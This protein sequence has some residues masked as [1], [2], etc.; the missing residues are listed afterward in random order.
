MYFVIYTFLRSMHALELTS[1]NTLCNEDI[2][3]YTAT[4]NDATPCGSA[5]NVWC[6]FSETPTVTLRFK[7][8]Q[9]VRQVEFVGNMK[10]RISENSEWYTALNDF[11][12][13]WSL[14]NAS[15]E[16]MLDRDLA[17]SELQFFAIK[18]ENGNA[19]LNVFGCP[20]RY[21]AETSF[22]FNSTSR[23]LEKRF[24]SIGNFATDFIRR[25]SQAAA[26]PVESLLFSGLTE[27]GDQW[28]GK[29][30]VDLRILPSAELTAGQIRAR[31]LPGAAE[32]I[33]KFIYTTQFWIEDLEPFVCAGKV[34]EAGH[35]CLA[36]LCVAQDGGVSIAEQRPAMGEVLPPPRGVTSEVEPAGKPKDPRPIIIAV[37][38]LFAVVF[39]GY[40][41]HQ[42]GN[43]Q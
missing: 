31:L 17:T 27:T 14:V 33:D 7:E 23:A 40:Q 28:E 34:C 42:R 26:I 8:P 35:M 18:P 24:G 4:S 1:V 20:K 36:G 6:F 22:A 3:I 13:V 32:A 21:T 38:G 2:S 16:A 25:L 19:T 12:R 11:G 29:I 41:S 37:V 9:V 43:E 5:H 10:M 15:P 39:G 30:S